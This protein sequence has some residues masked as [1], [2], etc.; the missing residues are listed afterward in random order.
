MRKLL[1][2]A[3]IAPALAACSLQDN[4]LV[5]RTVVSTV[6]PYFHGAKVDGQ[7]FE[8][9]AGNVY[10]FQWQWYRSLVIDTADGLVVI[11]PMNARMA[12]ALK[13]E[14]D[15]RFPGK[16]VDT[17]IYSHYH[18]DHA[19]GGAALHPRNVIAHAKSPQYWAAVADA[20]KVLAPTR[21]IS[22]DTTLTIGGVTIE[23]VQIPPS[24]SD[25][26]FAFYLPAQR[27]VYAPDLA[28]V[29]Y[30]APDAVP[31]NYMPGYIEGINKVL[32]LDFDTLVPGHFG[33]GKK[34]DM[35]E[36]RDM[37]L[38]GCQ[39][40]REALA[41]YGGPGVKSGNWAKYFD[42]MYPK[43]K[44]RYGDWGG[45]NEMFVLNFVG[46]VTGEALGY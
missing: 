46:D 18:L 27:L 43:M 5:L 15:R 13:A 29:R 17:L 1:L 35:A 34:Q 12:T 33:I 45:F 42:Y 31:N 23:A 3:A 28:F 41:L 40:A 25:T 4:G 7:S 26:L 8:Q 6:D 16:S 37:L 2:L 38:Y 21:L 36:Y 32:K 44:A 30:V 39:L 9:L 22:G 24:H 14:L 11:D 19:S 10:T 20:S